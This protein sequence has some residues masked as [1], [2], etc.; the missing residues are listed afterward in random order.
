MKRRKK[1]FSF[2]FAVAENSFLWQ[3]YNFLT[4]LLRKIFFLIPV[5]SHHVNL[6]K[7]CKSDVKKLNF[8]NDRFASCDEL[9]DFVSL[10]IQ[11]QKN[12]K[13]VEADKSLRLEGEL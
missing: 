10:F 9:K 12:K 8:V 1:S 5:A 4:K 11:R 3:I 13:K 6:D 7:F 2:L